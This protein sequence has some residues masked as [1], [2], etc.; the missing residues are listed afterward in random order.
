MNVATMVAVTLHTVLLTFALVELCSGHPLHRQAVVPKPLLSELPCT[1]GPLGMESQAI[2][3]S[4]I[5]ASSSYSSGYLPSKAR[6]NSGSAW[7]PTTLENQWLQVDLGVF[8]AI[9]G[10]IV[11][12]RPNGNQYVQ[13]FTVQYSATGESDDWESLADTEGET[14]QFEGNN[15]SG[16]PVTVDF[17]VALI[18]RFFRIIPAT[19]VGH[20]WLSLEIRG[21]QDLDGMLRLL[22]GDG[23]LSGRVEIYHDNVWGAICN[24]GWDMKE[25]SIVCHQLGFLEAEAATTVSL[26]DGDD[27][28]IVMNRV[29]CKG[30][31]RRLVDCPFLCTGNHRCNGSQVAGVK[32]KPNIIRLA[33]G[34]NRSSGRVEIYQDYTWGTL[35]DTDW[36][37]TDA[38]VVCRQLGFSGAEEAKSGAHFG[39]GEGP[40][41]MDGLACDGSES[42]IIDCPSFCWEDLRCNHTRDAGVVCRQGSGESEGRS[43]IHL[44]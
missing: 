37:V 17:P 24:N 11:R 2:P 33:G 6:P 15:G 23:V 4:S 12:G 21:C 10:V 28:P 36:D 22:D 27:I 8:T 39:Q 34:S 19:W 3:D 1:V 31:E 44:Q 29:S 32:C 38:E 30:S 14:V 9:A 40:V 13:T 7:A 26:E 20:Y 43:D 16:A 41:F 5:T 35:C 18:G 42:R 25:A